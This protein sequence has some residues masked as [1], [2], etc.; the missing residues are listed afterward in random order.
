MQ[1]QYLPDTDRKGW[2]HRLKQAME[3]DENHYSMAIAY[4]SDDGNSLL[5]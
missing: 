1:I 5:E 4:Y 3:M 2:S